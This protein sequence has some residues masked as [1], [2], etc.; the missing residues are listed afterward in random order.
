MSGSTKYEAVM[1]KRGADDCRRGLPQRS[2][3]PMYIQ[4]Y[5]FE[6]H[7][8]QALTHISMEREERHATK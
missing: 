2:E 5:S 4:G 3:D 1:W 7:A 6:Y 8:E